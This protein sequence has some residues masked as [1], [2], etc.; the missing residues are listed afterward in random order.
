[1][2]VFILRIAGVLQ[3]WGTHTF[4][5]S[6]PSALFPTRSGVAGLLGACLGIDREDPGGLRA[7][8]DGFAYCARLDRSRWPLVRIVDFQTVEH[9]RK[10]DGG[11][12]ENPV[13]SRR[14]YLCDAKFTVAL[15]LK[16]SFPFAHDRLNSDFRGGLTVIEI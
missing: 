15:S 6:R 10:V 7:V 5:D 4:E 14:Q 8:S 16:S 9:A 13:L 3:A 11:V 1:M 2:D 12:S